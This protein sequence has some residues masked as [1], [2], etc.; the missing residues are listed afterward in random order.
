MISTRRKVVIVGGG[1]AGC[2]SAIALAESGWKVSLFEK[3]TLLSGTSSKT[4]G[5]LGL[6]FH[7]MDLQTSEMLLRASIRFVKTFPGF[8]IGETLTWSNSLRHGRYFITNDSLASPTEILHVYESLKQVYANIVNEDSSSMVFGHPDNFYRILEMEE[9]END[10]NVSNVVLGIET[11]EHLINWKEFQAHLE[12]CVKSHENISVCERAELV[13]AKRLHNDT[14]HRFKLSFNFE[15]KNVT[16]YSDYV[17]NS[18]WH[19]IDKLNGLAGFP[20][21]LIPRTNRLKVLLHVRLPNSMLNF[22]S[23][24]FCIG[25]FC[26]LANLGDGTALV[27]YAPVTNINMSTEVSVSTDT[28]R[29]LTEGPSEKES[30]LL[31]DGI[32]RGA[33]T[34]IPGLENAEVLGLNFGIVQTLG[35]VNLHDANSPFHKRAYFGV[36]SESA[37]WI[38]NPCMKLIYMLENGDMVADIL[39]EQFKNDIKLQDAGNY[40]LAALQVQGTENYIKI[41]KFGQQI[42]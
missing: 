33:A 20:P 3:N 1:A 10:V 24:F 13:D 38:S 32:R 28:F 23:M 12:H 2:G 34:F 42:E 39:E 26:M 31:S 29:L 4:A 37:G 9:Y 18:T 6:G 7:Y 25:A 19:E 5:R 21:Y 41:E 8:R 14:E 27:S 22:H 35:A 11:A 30:L 36:R 16:V 15:K 17:V 40:N